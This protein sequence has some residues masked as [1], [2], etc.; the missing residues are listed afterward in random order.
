MAVIVVVPAV[1]LDTA[2]VTVVVPCNTVTDAGT[3]AT[4]AS[5]EL[6]VTTLPPASAALGNVT[7][8]FCEAF[9]SKDNVP[10]V[11]V[12]TPAEF[13]CTDCVAGV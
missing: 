6:R 5:L 10:G 11:S 4:N 2:T 3:V 12:I 9:G 8:R 7:V 1:R 13:T